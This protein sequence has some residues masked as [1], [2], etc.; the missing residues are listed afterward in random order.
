MST[1]DCNPLIGIGL[2]GIVNLSKTWS[3]LFAGDANRDQNPIRHALC[4]FHFELTQPSD[5]WRSEV[6]AMGVSAT[7]WL[8]G[9]LAA[10][11]VQSTFSESTAMAFRF[12]KLTVKDRKRCSGLSNSLRTKATAA[13]GNAPP[14]ALL[15]E[16][17]GI[18]RPLVQKIGANPQQLQ[19]A[20]IA[21]IDRLPKVSG[22]GGQLSLASDLNQVF[23][24]AQKQAEQMKDAFVSTEHPL[25]DS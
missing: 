23:D 16:Q 21:E 5:E 18:I 10:F 12:D 6:A 19:A 17:E 15:D 24:S 9:H 13:R 11:D 1:V 20:A 2:R 22:V 3:P 14:G 25:M 7:V 8:L 4:F